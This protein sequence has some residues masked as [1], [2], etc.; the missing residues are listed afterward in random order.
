[1]ADRGE[2]SP[3]PDRIMRD[4]FAMS[5]MSGMYA[6]GINTTDCSFEEIAF[7][8]YRQADAM[9]S[10]R[11]PKPVI[12]DHWAIAKEMVRTGSR[13]ECGQWNHSGRADCGNCGKCLVETK[14][15]H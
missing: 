8:S 15:A 2:F 14:G 9:M 10:A 12:E 5:A 13:C 7:S 4:M 6:A 1:M 3:M 11:D